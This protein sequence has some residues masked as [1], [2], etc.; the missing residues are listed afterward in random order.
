MTEHWDEFFLKLHHQQIL[1]E[2]LS[3]AENDESW[4]MISIEEAMKGISKGS[5]TLADGQEIRFQTLPVF[6]NQLTISLP[7][8]LIPEVRAGQTVASSKSFVVQDKLGGILFGLHQSGQA[9]D[10]TQIEI[11]QQ[12]LI[13]Q[14]SRAQPSMKLVDEKALSIQDTIIGCYEAIFLV[15]PS[16]YYQIVFVRSWRGKAVIGSYQFKLEDAPLWVPLTYAMLHTAT[17]SELT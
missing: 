15:S 14:T 16:P 2:Q 5:L 12:Q 10:P 8:S 9:L 11:Y 7:D 17:W 1:K 4:M 6:E 13:E 3:T